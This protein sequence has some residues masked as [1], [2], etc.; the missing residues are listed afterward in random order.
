MIVLRDDSQLPLYVA[1]DG[2][3]LLELLHGGQVA[4]RIDDLVD[5]LEE[6]DVGGVWEG[7][8]IDLLIRQPV[9]HLINDL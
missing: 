3:Q 8:G 7:D 9:P 4:H 5:G 6:L 1:L 2:L